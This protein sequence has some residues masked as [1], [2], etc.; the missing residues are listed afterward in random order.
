MQEENP[1][2]IEEQGI[3]LKKWV[4]LFLRNWLFFLV[5]IILALAGAMAFISLSTVQYEVTSNVLVN[6]DNNPLDKAQ[7]FSTAIYNDPYQ[8]ENEMGVLRARSVT[9]RT[10]LQ[11]DFFTSYFVGGRF[12]KQELYKSTP[13][14]VEKD[15]SH[16]Q[17]VG[18]F[19][20]LDFINDTLIEISA[21]DEEVQIYDYS[22]N[23]VIK[24]I[25]EFHFIDTVEFG[26]ITG[27]SYCR[28]LVLPGFQFV[29]KPHIE[30]VYY[31]KFYGLQE[32]VNN[33]KNFRIDNERGSSILTVSIRYR[34]PQKASDFIN[35]LTD[36]YLIK[37]LERDNKIAE[38]TIDFIDAQLTDLVDSLKLSGEKLQD[39]QSSKKVIDIGF[40]AEKVYSKLE[41]LEAEKAK[42][43]VKKRYFNFLLQNLESKSDVSDLITPTTLE[44]ND[45]VLNS[46]IIELAELYGER[47]EMS[48]NS[49]K[50]NPYLSSLELKIDDTRRKL[51]EASSSILEATEI[52]I[53]ETD[54]QILQAEQTLNR[55]PK[56]KQ[57]LL[58][59]ERK[60][61]LNDEL[62]TYLLT[63]RS[64]ME[65]FRASNI[66]ANEVLDY[67]S[68]AEAKIVSP[69]I[70]LNM[71][72][73]VL[74]GLF[75]P[76]AFL[77]FRESI[78]NKIKERDDIQRI[79]G[80]PL[81]GQVV[82]SRANTFP[83][84]LDE[85][86]SVLTESYRTLRTNLQFVINE[87]ESNIIL[88]TSAVQG[89]GKSYTALN[90]ASVYAF[91]GKRTVLV[92]FD[93]RKSRIVKN[94]D[95]KIEK[96]LSNYL[97]KN[98]SFEEIIY[99][100]DKLNFDLIVS[101]P[102]PPNPSE[103]VSSETTKTLFKRLKSKYDIIIVDSP[104]LGIVSDAL[105]IYPYTDIT[106]MVVRFNFTTEEVLQNVMEDIRVRK[107]ERVSIVLNDV[108]LPRSRYGYSYGYAYGYAGK[109]NTKKGFLRKG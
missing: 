17:P 81:V 62:Y 92:D 21:D 83:A 12:N 100:G 53:E 73:A 33:F 93:L 75:F 2:T 16:V 104:P 31:F 27:N 29:V 28:F 88:V 47:S 42:L 74:L 105:L 59:I 25:P 20:K 85:P 56:D 97:S 72:V 10:I 24:T 38:A 87:S 48:F 82:G 89:E 43:L 102:V 79:T 45:P 7:L 49:I 41:N 107:I 36:E 55:L 98:S 78:N 51:I 9:R 58:N 39:F 11:L 8:L 1:L 26:E 4:T 67:A 86:N 46:L 95:I 14:T 106:L 50:D 63:R 64:E 90:L 94:L 101:G 34:N 52:A 15:T 76:G 6:N 70:K 80:L 99:K 60:F 5:C 109:D 30:N 84:V 3:D 61:K 91:Y 103:L 35:K 37:G 71:I 68:V 44:I 77:Y 66:P 18:I 57:Q 96:G 40:Q 22:K 13:F 23:Q 32:L 65:I 69:N 19:F 54:T 108:H